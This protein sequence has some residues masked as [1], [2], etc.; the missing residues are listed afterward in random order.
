MMGLFGFL[1]IVLIYRYGFWHNCRLLILLLIA[2]AYMGIRDSI[3]FIVPYVAH[4]WTD[5][6]FIAA[7]CVFILIGLAA[8]VAGRTLKQA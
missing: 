4:F 7:V 3:L 8:L 1:A 6:G 2:S 5:Y